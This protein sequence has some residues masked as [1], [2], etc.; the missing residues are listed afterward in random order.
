[1]GRQSQIDLFLD[2]KSKLTFE[3]PGITH[4]SGSAH[5]GRLVLKNRQDKGCFKK[6]MTVKPREGGKRPG[7]DGLEFRTKMTR[8]DN[9]I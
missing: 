7:Q 3:K 1:M 9:M 4:Q 2:L 6:K 8:T 5:W